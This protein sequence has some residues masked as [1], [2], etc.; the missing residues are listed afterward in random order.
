MS[1]WSENLD[2]F[3]QNEF[4]TVAAVNSVTA[5]FL[6]LSGIFDQSY[7]DLF[8]ELATGRKFVFKVQT[9]LAIELRSG[10][11]LIIDAKAY[12]IVEF[13]PIGDGKLTNIILKET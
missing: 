9:Q 10:D 7:E 6:T 11:R 2:F 5:T 12:Q 3:T 1:A 8:G 4:S 13:N